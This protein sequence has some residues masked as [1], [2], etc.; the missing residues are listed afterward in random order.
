MWATRQGAQD[1][2]PTK[3]GFLL[4]GEVE[5][6]EGSFALFSS[7]GREIYGSH[8]SRKKRGMD[9]APRFIGVRED[10]SMCGPPAREAQLP[11]RLALIAFA[12]F[13]YY[14]EVFQ[15][16]GVAFDFAAGG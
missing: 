7:A 5:L 2:D 10:K 8:P 16:R 12:E 15:R 4:G 3:L 11:G 1:G 9:G 13:G 6:H 14:L